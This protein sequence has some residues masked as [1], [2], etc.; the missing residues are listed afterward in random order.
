MK[1]AGRRLEV[2][3]A[4]FAA[5]EADLWLYDPKTRVAIVGD[6]VVDIVPFM[7]TACP[8]GWKKALDEVKA[9]PF[10]TLIPGHGA[11]MTRDD[12]A[13]WR[14]AFET[15]LGCAASDR[16]AAQC[17]DGWMHDAAGF[18]TLDEADDAR[19]LAEA[20]VA[21]VLRVPA[22]ERMAYCSAKK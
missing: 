9:T 14:G 17:A 13:R 1:I 8:D 6:L 3:V 15:W 10:V 22:G 5:T 19:M 11:P 4:P 20:Y 12:F 21:R 16:T 18:Y 2:H 7:D